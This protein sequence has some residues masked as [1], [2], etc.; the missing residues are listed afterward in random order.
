LN[1][2]IGLVDFIAT[3]AELRLPGTVGLRAVYVQTAILWGAEKILC[4]IYQWKWKK[5]IIWKGQ[6]LGHR[7]GGIEFSKVYRN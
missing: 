5:K 2:I 6:W 3:Y 4:G 7:G 1:G